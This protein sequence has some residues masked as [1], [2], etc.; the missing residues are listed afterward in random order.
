MNTQEQEMRFY[1]SGA[2]VTGPLSEDDEE[3]IH[4]LKDMTEREL[5]DWQ[6]LRLARI[7][8]DICE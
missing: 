2:M 7:Y 5:T 6:S 4:G 3:F 1:L 8:E